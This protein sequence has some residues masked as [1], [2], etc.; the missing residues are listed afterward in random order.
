VAAAITCITTRIEHP[1]ITA[2]CRFLERLG[3]QITYLPVDRFGRVDPDDLNRA[4]TP[5]T[6]LISIM[7][8]NN[9]VGTIQPIEECA[10]I[11]H[12]HGRPLSYRCRSIG[13]Q[14]CN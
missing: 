7:H 5:R 3:A 11:A 1:A 14:D 12:E 9:E 13:R 6:I 2:P 4:I 10:R 8:A